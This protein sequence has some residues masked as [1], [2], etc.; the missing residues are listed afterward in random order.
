MRYT[1]H[2]NSKEVL[3]EFMGKKKAPMVKNLEEHVPGP[4]MG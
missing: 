2:R 1:E 4:R 3:L